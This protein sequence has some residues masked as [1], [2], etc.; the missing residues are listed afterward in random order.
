MKAKVFNMQNAEVEE[1]ELND[2]VFAVE[3]NE[4][5]I[6]EVI[7]AQDANLNLIKTLPEKVVIENV[8]GSA[9]KTLSKVLDKLEISDKFVWFNTEED[10][11]FHGIGKYDVTP[12][13]E[14]AF[15]DY[16]V[17]ATVLSKRP[18]G[19]KY[20]YIQNSDIFSICIFISRLLVGIKEKV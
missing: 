7:V 19:E 15:Y 18:N 13:G 10:P 16:S 3:Y 9:Y 20:F 1:I 12:K 17:D 8:G 11:F 2:S 6:H 4:A 14:K 5:L